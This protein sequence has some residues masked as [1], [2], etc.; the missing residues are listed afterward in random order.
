MGLLFSPQNNPH[1]EETERE[2]ERDRGQRKREKEREREREREIHCKEFLPDC[3]TGE[4]SMK[5]VE[6]AN[7][8]S[9]LKFLAMKLQSRILSFSKKA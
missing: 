2:R 5:S 1:A 3:E 8:K 4:V 6:Q 7:R 9:R